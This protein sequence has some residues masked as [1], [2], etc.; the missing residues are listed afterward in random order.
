M[1][2]YSFRP[3]LTAVLQA[4]V[5]LASIAISAG[6]AQSAEPLAPLRVS[7]SGRYL[8]TQNDG[9]PFFWLADTGWHLFHRLKPNE[10]DRYLQDRAAKGFTVIQT[11]IVGTDDE[12]R[13]SDSYGGLAFQQGDP[14]RLVEA[15]FKN[16]D[17]IVAK[18]NS[19]GLRVAI[20]P[21]WGNHVRKTGPNKGSKIFNV[22]N[23]RDYGEYMG[24]RYRDAAVVW[25]V[26]GDCLVEKGDQTIWQALA[27]GLI[28]GGEGQ[29]LITG[30]F[31]SHYRDGS[32][33]HF[34]NEPWLDFNFAYSGHIWD[35]PSYEAITLDRIR[36]PIKPVIDGEPP[37]ENQPYLANGLRY[38]NRRKAWNGKLRGDA[39]LMRKAAYWAMLAGA[40]GHSYGAGDIWQFYDPDRGDEAKHHPNTVWTKALDFDGARQMGIMRRLFELFPWE[41]LLPDQSVI[42]KGQGPEEHHAQAARA[43]DG[44]FAI[45]YLPM[46]DPISIRMDVIS[47]KENTPVLARWFDPRN[48][49]WTDIGKFKNSGTREFTPPSNGKNNDWVLVLQSQKKSE[50]LKGT[51]R[52]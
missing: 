29:H 18:A 1:F 36:T 23:A 39:H 19:M 14:G 45:A 52:P 37:Y 15:F 7:D 27:E 50:T 6:M 25:L 44:S 12:F 31:R 8:V 3:L 38:F 47:D 16:V 32:S 22:K 4:S 35:A 41:T 21:T 43:C 46:G 20:A 5:L 30:H 33:W 17:T 51:S 13:V 9:Q 49:K 40:A 42:T 34:H 26:G 10:V 11:M 28:A 2:R 48:E 24:R